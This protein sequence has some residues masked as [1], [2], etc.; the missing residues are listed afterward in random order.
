MFYTGPHTLKPGTPQSGGVDLTADETGEI[1]PHSRKLVATG[2]TLAMNPGQVGLIRARSGLSVKGI[3]IG[4]GVIDSDYR[5]PVKVLLI[6]SSENPFKYWRGDRI[7]QLIIVQ[8][9]D[10]SQLQHVEEL[11][12]SEN[13]QR[14]ANGFGST[15]K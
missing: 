10:Y 5:G 1:P 2:L 11:P 4:A 6:N 9:A 13:N 7:A 8:H 15:G 14:G 3:D 12:I